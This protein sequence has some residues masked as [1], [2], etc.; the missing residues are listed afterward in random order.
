MHCAT[1][2]IFAFFRLGFHVCFPHYWAYVN[3]F[4]RFSFTPKYFS[5]ISS[6]VFC[7]LV[8]SYCFLRVY[9]K[10]FSLTPVFHH[11]EIF[12]H[13]NRFLHQMKELSHHSYISSQSSDL[14]YKSHLASRFC[15][16]IWHVKYR[17]ISWSTFWILV[18]FINFEVEIFEGS[19]GFQGVYRSYISYKVL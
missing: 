13:Q 5:R 9:G 8:K 16:R 10:S 3:S 11:S 4:D 19:V 1:S 7:F 14:L 6:S 12:L 17:E 18:V 2:E 15:C